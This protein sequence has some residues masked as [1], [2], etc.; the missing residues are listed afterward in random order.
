M[1]GT[2]SRRGECGVRLKATV[3][4]TRKR[5]GL[6]GTVCPPVTSWSRVDTSSC[7]VGK[8][9]SAAVWIGSG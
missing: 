9:L 4:E 5:E 8:I 1:G 6:V 3:T 2:G 7:I